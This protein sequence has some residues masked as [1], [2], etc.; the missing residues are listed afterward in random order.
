MNPQSNLPEILEAINFYD[1]KELFEGITNIFELITEF[2]P[3]WDVA[4]NWNKAKSNCDPIAAKAEL[5]ESL[6]NNKVGSKEMSESF[7]LHWITRYNAAVNSIKKSIKSPKMLSQVSESIGSLTLIKQTLM[8]DET[9]PYTSRGAGDVAQQPATSSAETLFK[10]P[11]DMLADFTSFKLRANKL[12][13]QNISCI[14][15]EDYTMERTLNLAK[16]SLS[17]SSHSCNGIKD[18]KHIQRMAAISIAYN[19]AL[20]LA[21]GSIY[22]LSNSLAL[23]Q[24][25]NTDMNKRTTFNGK[26]TVYVEGSPI[27]IDL[28]GRQIKSK[29][30]STNNSRLA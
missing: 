27:E 26:I 7:S 9:M 15:G 23:Y 22:T 6:K 5:L 20:Y 10:M 11:K 21:L 24:P 25:R 17:S 19:N 29:Q 30:Y 18:F 28:F 2:H 1:E 3:E 14:M 8:N 12:Q 13:C 4:L 16:T